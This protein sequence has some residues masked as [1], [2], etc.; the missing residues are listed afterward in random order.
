MPGSVLTLLWVV[1][2]VHLTGLKSDDVSLGIPPAWL[3]RDMAPSLIFGTLS[4]I[5]ILSVVGYYFASVV[6]R[7]FV[8]YHLY[9]DSFESLLY[10]IFCCIC[11]CIENVVMLSQFDPHNAHVSACTLCLVGDLKLLL[12]GFRRDRL[13][14]LS[15]DFRASHMS[16]YI[17]PVPQFK[18]LAGCLSLSL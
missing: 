15:T 18:W 14:L 11:G 12:C 3:G 1:L 4:P 8:L 16:T 6:I 2:Y 10:Y 17:R 7:I 9:L 13:N 5:C